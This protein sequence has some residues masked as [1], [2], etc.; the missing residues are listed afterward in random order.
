MDSPGDGSPDAR[1]ALLPPHRSP[2]GAVELA[3]RFLAWPLLTSTIGPTAYVFAAHPNSEAARFRNALAGHSVAL[4]CGLAALTIYGVMRYPS[5]STTESPSLQQV[6]AAVT[7]SASPSCCSNWSAPI[8]RHQQR[9][10][11]SSRPDWPVKVLCRTLP[12]A[13]E[14][15]FG[16]RSHAAEKDRRPNPP[17]IPGTQYCFPLS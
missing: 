2:V 6:A 16:I 4:G 13:T 1:C 3:G 17:E 8:T 9:Q 11:C 14:K 12:P 15:L 7:G 5:I 10:L